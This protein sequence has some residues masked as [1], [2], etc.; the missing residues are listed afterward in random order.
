[1]VQTTVVAVREQIADHLRSEIISGELAPNQKLTEEVLAQRFGVSRGRI[2][3]VLLELSKEGLLIS[4]A[5]KGTTVND[6][7][8]PDV[9]A[10]MIKLRLQI[11]TFA[12]RKV[13]KKPDEAFLAELKAALDELAETLKEGDFTEVT[14]ADIAFH[15]V[16]VA[17]AGEN[18][19]VNLWQPVIMR[20]RMNYQRIGKPSQVVAEHEAIYKAIAMGD[21]KAA[22]EALK[23]NI[24]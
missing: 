3:D 4:R 16:I 2:R 24:R 9:Q 20:M 18:D 7:A 23:S 1:M 10:L 13:A 11:E 6:I 8:P 5:N 22:V 19:L 15:R 17:N 14:K 21:E 12:V